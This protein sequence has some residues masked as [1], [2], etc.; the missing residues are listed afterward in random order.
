MS[1]TPAKPPPR[2][3]SYAGPA[4]GELAAFWSEYD[5]LADAYDKS[6]ARALNTDLDSLLVFAGLFSGVNSTALFYS[7]GGLS[8]NP[9]DE[10]NALLRLLVTQSSNG[11]LAGS[12]VS[13]FVLDTAAVRMNA[14][15]AASL[16][17][18]L[19][20]AFGAV[21]GKQW[22]IHYSQTGQVG[23]LEKQCR[24]RQK[25]FA[26]AQRWHLQTVVELLPTLLQISLLAFFV[27]L[28]DFFWSLNTII[29]MVVMSLSGFA[30]LIYAFTTVAAV[31]DTKCPFQSHTTHRIRRTLY[32][33]HH[34]YTTRLRT[35]RPKRPVIA[36]RD[37]IR[38][39]AADLQRD[40]A[41]WMLE[42]AEKKKSL[43]EAARIIPSLTMEACHPI[44]HHPA[45]Y[46]LLSQLHASLSN[47]KALGDLGERSRK[48]AIVFGRALVYILLSTAD[49]SEKRDYA[50]NML[51]S[52]WP[53]GMWLPLPGS[54]ELAL[55]AFTLDPT[56]SDITLGGLSTI[57]SP[58]VHLYISWLVPQAVFSRAHE[59]LVRSLI[60][61]CLKAP[62]VPIKHVLLCAWA[63]KTLSLT[64]AFGCWSPS[65]GLEDACRR[66]RKAFGTKMLLLTLCQ[67]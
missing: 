9:V 16:V 59:A 2:S 13:K 63:L 12:G 4:P 48:D 8:A 53:D 46:R 55:I 6:M 36:D 11:T 60:S 22:L 37:R 43:L 66:W 5:V 54:E 45:Y 17:T 47:A 67:C 21:V 34:Y 29:A 32:Y 33:I 42:V 3:I 14:F 30:F 40:C 41:L 10:T 19:L 44:L 39:E 27:G 52:S 64:G 61:A 25:K 56:H 7:T 58:C 20:A 23:E 18:S 35:S 15:F 28:A 24:K 38:A 26:G 49:N 62:I 1:S 50:W 57:S 31:I 65:V 51:S